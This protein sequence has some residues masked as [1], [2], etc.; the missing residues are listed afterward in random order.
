MSL[1]TEA[2]EQSPAPGDRSIVVGTDGFTLPIAD[3]LMGRGFVTGKS[4]S[5]KSNTTTVVVE[6]LL[7]AGCPA[8]V[9]DTDGEYWPLADTFDAVHVGADPD[10]DHVVDVEDAPQLARVALEN[11]APII[12]DVSGFFEDD[13]RDVIEAVARELFVQEKRHQTPYLIV[14]EEMH[15]WVPEKG[16]DSLNKQL[17]KI[18][19]RGRKRGLGIL[20]VSQRPADVRKAYISQCNW[21][22][23]HRLTW[24]NDLDKAADVLGRSQ[25]EYLAT[26]DNGDALVQSDW[27]DDVR[28]TTFRRKRTQDTGSTP[29]LDNTRSLGTAAD[30]LGA[31]GDPDDENESDDDSIALVDVDPSERRDLTGYDVVAREVF[32]ILRERG[33]SK[34]GAL[35][36]EYRERV[37]DPA[38]RETVRRRF[39]QLDADGVIERNGRNYGKRYYHVPPCVDGDDV[40]ALTD[41]IADANDLGDLHEHL[42]TLAATSAYLVAVRSGGTGS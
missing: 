35:M 41:A 3:V 29:T 5:G 14:V 32:A 34:L 28:E 30:V 8:L 40:V 19:K 21:L 16:A 2:A 20:G 18:A 7:D 26:L 6:E 4:G 9:V 25:S 31:F 36:D 27:T 17:V 23:W 39:C 24:S 22:V 15:E 42:E 10:C 33:V 13:A 38:S 11:R 12:L 37:D 1:S